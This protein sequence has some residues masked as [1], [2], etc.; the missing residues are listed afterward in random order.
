M[1]SKSLKKQLLDEFCSI[2]K[3]SRKYAIRLF[4]SSVSPKSITNLSKRGRKMVYDDPVILEVLRDIWVVTNLPCSKRLKVI[5]P[6]WLP[7]Y[8]KRTLSKEITEKLLSASPATID[9][10]MAPSRARYNKLG[11]STTKP[12]SILKKHIPVKT[13]QWDETIPGFVEADTVAHC[14]NSVAG[15]FVFTLNC[16]DIASQ[17]TEQRAVWGKGEKGTLD[18]IKD[19]ESHLPFTLRGF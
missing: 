3:Y 19:I 13:K 17:W 14:G 10:L 12:G 9:R 18:A 15:M 7:F 16:V 2:C 4:N 8:T 6:V 11:L 5:L 1:A